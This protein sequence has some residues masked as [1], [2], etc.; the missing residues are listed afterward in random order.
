[1]ERM[2]NSTAGRQ[3]GRTIARELTR[4][5]LGALGIGSSRSKKKSSWF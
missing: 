5:I 3:I 4:G 1:L 2:V